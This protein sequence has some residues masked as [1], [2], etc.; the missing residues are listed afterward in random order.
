MTKATLD[1][2]DLFYSLSSKA[3]K[4]GTNYW[5]LHGE[6]VFS[7]QIQLP[8]LN[9]KQLLQASKLQ[10][11]MGA[12]PDIDDWH[13]VAAQKDEQAHLLVTHHET[14]QTWQTQQV[15]KE[16]N[17]ILLPDYLYCPYQENTWTL[18]VVADKILLRASHYAGLRMSKNRFIAL[19]K[20]IETSL[21]L[22]K[23]CHVYSDKILDENISKLLSSY[24]LE[25]K[26]DNLA[27]LDTVLD[28]RF[29]CEPLNLLQ[30]KYRPK[31]QQ[32]L[33]TKLASLSITTLALAFCFHVASVSFLIHHENKE[34]AQLN[35]QISKI[36]YR[37]FPHASAIVAPKVRIQRLLSHSLKYAN[38]YDFIRMLN[39]FAVVNNAAFHITD[40]IYHNKHMT[41][42]LRATQSN[43]FNQWLQKL[44]HMSPMIKI[45]QV[46]VEKG[47]VHATISMT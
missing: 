43:A 3:T 13:I 17:I 36:Y 12:Y 7:N 22:T 23:I 5:I 46:H 42:H 20:N 31:Q 2:P 4:P 47:M 6:L 19:F 8:K 27:H 18:L 11:A 21:S 16:K 1:T 9:Q 30:D 38:N 25:I 26:K 29:A 32:A 34:T 10:L 39:Q 14:M 44:K 33:T 37:L 24:E 40:L 45:K 41:L 15:T 35:Q 28:P